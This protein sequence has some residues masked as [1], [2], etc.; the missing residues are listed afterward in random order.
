MSKNDQATEKKQDFKKWRGKKIT[1]GIN[2]S[3]EGKSRQ[4]MAEKN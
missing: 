3:I 4:S 2:I 1:I